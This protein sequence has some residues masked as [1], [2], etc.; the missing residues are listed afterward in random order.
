MELHTF[1]LLLQA[2]FG[3]IRG[4]DYFGLV[5]PGKESERVDEC[6]ARNKEEKGEK[7]LQTLLALLWRGLA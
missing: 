5:S 3:L 6:I 2:I 7:H 1:R 4:D